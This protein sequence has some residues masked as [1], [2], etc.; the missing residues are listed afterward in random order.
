MSMRFCPKDG[1][2]MELTR[3]DDKY[4][5]VCPVCGYEEEIS[6]EEAAVILG[7]TGTTVNK[8]KKVK[9][10]SLVSE[11]KALKRSKEELQQEREETY[12]IFLDQFGG[13]ESS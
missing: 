6:E 13:E 9:T 1:A 3:K 4:V 8:H 2:M 11:G 7:V 12:E 10:T 5:L